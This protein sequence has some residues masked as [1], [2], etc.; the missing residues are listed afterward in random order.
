[1]G[2]KVRNAVAMSCKNCH[3]IAAIECIAL[4]EDNRIYGV[5]NCPQCGQQVSKDIEE[6]LATLLGEAKGSGNGHA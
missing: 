1:M 4:G 6:L 2:T 5:G 3:V